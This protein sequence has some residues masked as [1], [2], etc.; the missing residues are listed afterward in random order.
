MYNQVSQ[1]TIKSIITFRPFHYP[2]FIKMLRFI[3]D[4]TFV[5]H[6]AKVYHTIIFINVKS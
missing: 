5:T 6:N 1:F 4:F 2:K 3:G